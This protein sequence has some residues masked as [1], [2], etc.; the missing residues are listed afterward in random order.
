MKKDMHNLGIHFF[1]QKGHMCHAGLE[2]CELSCNPYNSS[3]ILVMG[4]IYVYLN[5]KSTI[6]RAALYALNNPHTKRH[7]IATHIHT[8][9][10]KRRVRLIR[11]WYSI[12]NSV[13]VLFYP[14]IPKQIHLHLRHCSSG[15]GN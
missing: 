10:R 4:C 5:L 9:Y 11:C 12:A 13:A 1:G 8:W 14:H 6:A 15:T 3:E 7:R 2:A